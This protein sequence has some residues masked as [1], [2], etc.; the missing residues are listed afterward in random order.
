MLAFTIVYVTV[1]IIFSLFDTSNLF[2]S[3]A[4]TFVVSIIL[5][6]AF[7]HNYFGGS[8]SFA[9][10]TGALWRGFSGFLFDCCDWFFESFCHFYVLFLRLFSILVFDVRLIPVLYLANQVETIE[11]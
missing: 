9:T 4:A 5:S 1:I 7:S 3:F 6:V 2:T 10:R 11:F 8:L